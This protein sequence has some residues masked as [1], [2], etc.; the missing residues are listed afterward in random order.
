MRYEYHNDHLFQKDKSGKLLSVDPDQT[1]PTG[2]KAFIVCHSICIF[3]KSNSTVRP[4]F[5]F[6]DNNSNFFWCPNFLESC[7]KSPLT[8]SKKAS[9]SDLL[10]TVSNF[11][12]FRTS[13]QFGALGA[14]FLTTLTSCRKLVGHQSSLEKKAKTCNF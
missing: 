13:L 3:Q 1:A 14:Q 4:L 12:T 6:S 5:K 2:I 7:G 8:D 9:F 11:E 10:I